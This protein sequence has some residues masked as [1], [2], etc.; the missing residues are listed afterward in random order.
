[1]LPLSLL[2][3][4]LHRLNPI[5]VSWEWEIVGLCSETGCTWLYQSAVENHCSQLLTLSPKS[6]AKAPNIRAVL[7]TVKPMANR[8]S[9]HHPR[10]IPN[11]CSGNSNRDSASPNRLLVNTNQAPVGANQRLVGFNATLVGP[12]RD[13]VGFNRTRVG[14]NHYSVGVY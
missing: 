14:A 10:V 1:M 7:L 12:N 5:N 3:D 13:C 11:T 8:K 4:E 9:Q 6:R 2:Y